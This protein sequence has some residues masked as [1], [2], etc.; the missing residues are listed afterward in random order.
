[1]SHPSPFRARIYCG[2]PQDSG[3]AAVDQATCVALEAAAAKGENTV[4]L[5][6]RGFEYEVDLAAL[7]Q[8]NLATNKTRAIR[9]TLDWK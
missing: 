8:R 4:S 3:W 1:M 2:V 5:S 9:R 7:A 6:Q